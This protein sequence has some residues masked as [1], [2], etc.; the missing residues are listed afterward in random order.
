MAVLK[1]VT[2]SVGSVGQNIVPATGRVDT[3]N[4]DGTVTT[5]N[6]TLAYNVKYYYY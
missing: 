3:T 4:S 1:N 5:T 6:H 2:G